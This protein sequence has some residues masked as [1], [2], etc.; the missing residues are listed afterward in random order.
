MHPVPGELLAYLQKHYPNGIYHLAYEAG[1]CGFWIQRSFTD[2]GIYCIVQSDDLSKMLQLFKSYTAR[3]VSDWRR[4][5][6]ARNNEGNQGLVDVQT[7]W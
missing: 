2:A 1:F 4:Y 3:T 6:R 7:A 5:S